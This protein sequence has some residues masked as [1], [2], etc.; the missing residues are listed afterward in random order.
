M[1]GKTKTIPALV[2]ILMVLA[3]AIT[4]G[5]MP[6]LAQDE[7]ETKT[8][9]TGLTAAPS[10]EGILLTWDDPGDDSITEYEI[11]R[12]SFARGRLSSERSVTAGCPV[13]A[14]MTPCDSAGVMLYCWLPRRCGDDPISPKKKTLQLRVV[15]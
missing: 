11:E 13:G 9:P 7:P 15:P 14:G 8:A 12:H 2:A 3:G 5:M 1:R 6:A 10:P 4:A